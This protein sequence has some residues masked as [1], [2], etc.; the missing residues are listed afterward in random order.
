MAQRLSALEEDLAFITLPT[1]DVLARLLPDATTLH[2]D[3]CEV[4][5]ATAQITLGVQSPQTSAPYPLCATLAWRIHSDY[6]RTLA[7][8]L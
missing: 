4:D 1:P 5:E 3:T 2:L 6:E 8:L 7:D